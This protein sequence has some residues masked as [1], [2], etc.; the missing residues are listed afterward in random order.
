MG[1]PGEESR[2]ENSVLKHRGG[3]QAPYISLIE[4]QFDAL[5]FVAD[6]LVPRNEP[7]AGIPAQ[8]RIVI[9]SRPNGFGFFVPGHRFTETVIS[10]GTREVTGL[11]QLG[12]AQSL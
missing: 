2:N 9:P 7:G 6:Q 8:Q 11:R 4:G 5:F 10:L 1:L 3:W 12:L